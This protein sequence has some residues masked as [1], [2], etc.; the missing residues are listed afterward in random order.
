MVVARWA[1][2]L[3]TPTANSDILSI[4]G[5]PIMNAEPMYNMTMTTKA[6]RHAGVRAF[7]TG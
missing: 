3:L 7:T 2:W 5:K 4:T 6:K 1:R